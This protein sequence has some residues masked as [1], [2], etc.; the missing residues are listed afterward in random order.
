MVEYRSAWRKMTS[1]K[2]HRYNQAVRSTDDK[3]VASLIKQ[4]QALLK[5]LKDQLKKRQRA[6]NKN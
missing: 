6:S 4:K 5:K 1:S 2:D 3:E